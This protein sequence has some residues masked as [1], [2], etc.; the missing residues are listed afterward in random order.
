MYTHTYSYF[1]KMWPVITLNQGY[2][3]PREHGSWGGLIHV[4]LD[5]KRH[6]QDMTSSQRLPSV[7]QLF[8]HIVLESV[9]FKWCLRHFQEISVDSDPSFHLPWSVFVLLT[10]VLTLGISWRGVTAA[11]TSEPFSFVVFFSFLLCVYICTYFS[12]FS[13]L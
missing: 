12:Y 5:S 9:I 3:Q 4:W 6:S 13:F 8:F 2:P 10:F 11:M 7:N 1:L